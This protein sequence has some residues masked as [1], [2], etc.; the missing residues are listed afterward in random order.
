VSIVALNHVLLIGTAADKADTLSDLQSLGC[1]ELV[2]LRKRESAPGAAP[3]PRALEALHF[4]LSCPRRRKQATSGEGFDAEEVERQ[5][6]EVAK[7]LKDCEDLSDVLAQR[8]VE[9]KPFGDFTFPPEEEMGGL[10]LWFYAVPHGLMSKVTELG[11]TWLTAASDARNQYIVVV[12]E[13]EPENLPVPRVHSG[14]L[15][16]ADLVRKLEDLNAEID[17]LQDQRSALT[18]W[19]TL[20]IQELDS[21]EDRDSREMASGLTLDSEQVFGLAAWAPVARCEELRDYARKRSLVCIIRAPLPEEEPPTILSNP[22][23]LDAGESLVTFYMTPGYRTWD[24]STIVFFSF[25][26]FYAMILADAGYA[27]VQALI[28]VAL[29]KKLSASPGGL[30]M[31]RLLVLLTAASV[32]YGVL[33]GGYFGVTPPPG[34]FL[35]KLA[36]ID[37]TNSDL[38]MGIS[39]I[40]G[41][42]HVVLANLM[43]ARRLGWTAS[44]LAPLGWALMILGGFFAA[45][46]V[47]L[48]FAALQKSAIGAALIGAIFVLLFTGTGKKP[49]AR[50]VS[51]LLAFT[52]ITAAFGDV[53]SYL[54]LFALG[55]ASASLAAAFNGMAGDLKESVSGGGLLLAGLILLVGHLLNF[56]LSISSAVI[57]GMRLNVIEF[58]N[59]GL[60]EEGK[61]FRPFKRKESAQ[62]KL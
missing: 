21:L 8:L 40:V 26:L 16:P 10:K 30:R 27:L 11:L 39:I 24:P 52:K 47:P 3:R 19:C 4:L 42:A 44:A 6:L 54:R 46:A 56:A 53:L 13:Q 51:G 32:I 25:A 2:P 41:V 61:L 20:Y 38:M 15:S 62:W 1:L 60:N 5:A 58:F 33:V 36:I 37:M 7:R 43:N 35:R 48:E 55:L 34:S 17:S 49:L 31:R 23:A 12:S 29:W 22:Q 18:R 50:A 45:V 14:Q 9:L 57:H 28:V 59:W